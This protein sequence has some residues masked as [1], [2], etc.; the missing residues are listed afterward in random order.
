MPVGNTAH[1]WTPLLAQP[2]RG[3]T[4]ESVQPWEYNTR[5]TS[6]GAL[7]PLEAMNRL[8]TYR[9][10]FLRA[11]IGLLLTLFVYAILWLLRWFFVG[12]RLSLNSDLVFLSFW[13]ASYFVVA[14]LI[15]ARRRL[16]WSLRNQMSAAYLLIAVVPVILVLTMVGLTAYLLYW[17]LG[18]YVLYTEMQ[19]RVTRVSTVAGGLATTMAIEAAATGKPTP[20]LA[21]PNQSMGFLEAAKADIPGLQVEIGKGQ[22]LLA[23]TGSTEASGFRG[24]VLSGHTL[25]FRAVQVR[26]VRGGK[27]FV[28]VSAPIT[29]QVL[30]TLPPN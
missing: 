27:V 24:I 7:K 3:T 11:G 9:P 12:S 26:A 13:T 16:L 20:L 19:T 6:G 1:L 8:R 5:H 15:W 2:L 28:S 30:D 4:L 18:S 17:Q 23:E 25:A 21:I 10:I 22:D 14:G 29:P